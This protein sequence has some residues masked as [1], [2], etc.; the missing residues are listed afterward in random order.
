MQTLSGLVLP[1]MMVRRF[2]VGFSYQTTRSGIDDDD[3][4]LA[5]RARRLFDRQH[6]VP[7]DAGDSPAK[8]RRCLNAAW[9]VVYQRL[10]SD[11]DEI[12]TTTS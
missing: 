6:V 4:L 8:A 1:S 3:V 2:Q 7:L 11:D 5:V 10:R 9:R 12:T